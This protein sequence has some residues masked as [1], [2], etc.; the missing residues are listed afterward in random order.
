MLT[1]FAHLKPT[2]IA[3]AITSAFS[4]STVAAEKLADEKKQATQQEIEEVVAI[5]KS[6][7]YANNATSQEMAKQQS[8]MTSALAVI[9]NLPGVLVNEGDT[10]GSDDWSTTVSIRGF[11]LSLDEQ[12]VGITIDGIANGNSN[13]GGGAKANRYIDTENLETVEV[14][15]GT[16]DISSRSNEALGGTLNFI[17]INPSPEQAVIASM[18]LGNFDAQKYYIR[19]E[20]GEMFNDTYGWVSYSNSTNSDWITGTAENQRDH[21][22]AK[23][24]NGMESNFTISAYLSYD[25][26]HEDNYQRVSLTDFNKNPESDG[27]LGEW[28]GIPYIDQVYRQGWSTLRENLFGYIELNTQ[29]GEVELTANAYFHNNEGRGDWV[30]PYLVD[31]NNDG[32]NA[33]SELT[34]G[35]TVYGGNALGRLYFVDKHGK[36]LSPLA[37]CQSSITFPYGGAGAHADPNCYASGAIPVGSY[38]HTHYQKDRY[39]INADGRWETK[40]N[41][42]TNVLRAGIWYEDYERAEHRDW[43]KILDSK[44]SYDFDHT[45]YWVQYDRTYPV[46][47]MMAYLEDSFEM[48]SITLRAGIKQYFVDLQSQ[49]HFTQASKSVDS[50]SDLLVSA[51]AVWFT[52][53]EG[54]EVFAG[55][56]EN[57]AAIK[58][59]VLEADSSALNN[60]EP[61]TAE[62]TD[63]GIRFNDTKVSASV[64]FYNIDF[65]NRLTFIAPGSENGND[66]LV[67][68]NGSYINTGGIESSGIETALTYYPS[69]EF[70]VYAS[71][72]SNKS[73]YSTGSVG[74]AAGNTVF[75]SVENMAVLSVDWQSNQ[76]SAGISTKWLGDRWM[77]PQNTTRIDGYAVSDLYV[78][79]D[80]EN[81]SSPLQGTSLRLTVNNLF[82][83]SYIG[84]VAGGWGGWIGAPRTAAINFQTRF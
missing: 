16:A 20:T 29:I 47:T 82:D 15:Q 69:N 73:E 45:P 46:E 49:D 70:S 56:A 4:T 35:N 57:F 72:T 7:S 67:G 60:V 42:N 43:H 55:Y 9:D 61:E 22:A 10:F 14:S 80:L 13:Y 53:I 1:H 5:G 2:L 23:L 27:L 65:A 79:I 3:V 74:F 50:N 44:S 40:I 54:L 17:T 32:S 37:D 81:L 21:F 34:S 66:Y 19:L 52:P 33:H 58:D 26:V 12:Q 83:K 75:G 77:D 48:E 31:V 76:Y 62:N 71:Y 11:Q 51:G 41:H 39:G 78:A 24:V 28:S 25:D 6:V 68:T 38:R 30:P 64:T 63:F 8:T 36:A 59:Q 18:S 84:G